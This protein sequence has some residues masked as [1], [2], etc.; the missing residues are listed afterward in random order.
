V[1]RVRRFLTGLACVV[2]VA[3][4]GAVRAHTGHPILRAERTIKF[5][6]VGDEG[7]RIVVTVNYGGEQMLRMARRADENSDGVVDDSEVA[8]FM[9]DWSDELRDDLP[10]HVD[11]ERVRPRFVRPF[12]EPAGPVSIRPG[13]LEIVATIPLA[14]GRHE[15]SL[16]DDM[17]ADDFDRTDVMFEVTSEATLVASGPSATPTEV[18]PSFAYGRSTETRHVRSMGLAFT[19]PGGDESSERPLF[20]YVSIFLVLQSIFAIGIGRLVRAMRRRDASPPR[21]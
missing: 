4:G 16:E 8:E 2:I 15:V 19:M 9:D 12:F 21:E 7:L 6:A 13:T 1:N 10:V 17:R 14:A 20:A 5:E 3:T 18:V 11:G